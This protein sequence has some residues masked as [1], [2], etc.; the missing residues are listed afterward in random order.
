MDG[1]INIQCIPTPMMIWSFAAIPAPAN[2]LKDEKGNYVFD[3][4]GNYVTTD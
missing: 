3:Q 1:V 2:A 4:N